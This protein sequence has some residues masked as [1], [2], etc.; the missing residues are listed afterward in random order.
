MEN[1][2]YREMDRNISCPFVVLTINMN[3]NEYKFAFK[4]GILF[5]F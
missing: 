4:F 3:H 5:A 2:I 1:P